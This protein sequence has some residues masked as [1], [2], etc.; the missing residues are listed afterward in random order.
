[1]HVADLVTLDVS[2]LSPVPLRR[3]ILAAY[4]ARCGMRLNIGEVAIATE[5]QV[6]ELGVCA[7]CEAVRMAEVGDAE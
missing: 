4:P 6:D 5:A 1:V 2:F 7:R 3:Q